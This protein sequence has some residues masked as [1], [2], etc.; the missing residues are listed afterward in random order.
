MFYHFVGAVPGSTDLR[1]MLVRLLKYIGVVDV[2]NLVIFTSVTDS[3]V[4]CNTNLVFTHCSCHI[5]TGGGGGDDTT[6]SP[7][8]I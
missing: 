8:Y 2:S 7:Q 3:T 1:Q 5:I 6:E 4:C